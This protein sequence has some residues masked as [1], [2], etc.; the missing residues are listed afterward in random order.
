MNE[1]KYAQER[2]GILATAV[3]L[4]RWELQQ[5]DPNKALEHLDRAAQQT[6]ELLR[7]ALL[8]T[9]ADPAKVEAFLP[10]LGYET[11]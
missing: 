1:L 3:G 6:R 5:G 4:A 8:E 2:A 11:P 9:G 10:A 7:D